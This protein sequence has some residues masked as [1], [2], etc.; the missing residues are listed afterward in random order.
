MRTLRL[1]ALSDD[2][3][4][5]G[6]RRRGQRR[7]RRR[8]A[9]RAPHRRPRCAPRPA[10]TPA[11]SPRSTSTSAPSCR[12]RVIQARIRAGE[13]PEQVAAA[14][15]TRVERIMRFAHP[16]LQERQRV[17]EQA[18]EARVRLS[19]GSP[20]VAAA[21][22][23]VRAAAAASTPT[24]TRSPGTP[25]APTTARW[26]VT[27]AWRAGDE[28]GHHPLGLRPPSRT[29]APSDAATTDFA[30]GTRLVR[31]VP[32]VP[33]G[34]PPRRHPRPPRRVHA[35]C[36]TGQPRADDDLTHDDRPP[37]TSC[38]RDLRRLR[39]AD[40]AHV[41]DVHAAGGSPDDDRSVDALL[42]EVADHDTV[43][44]GRTR[45]GEDA[46]TRAPASRPGRT[47]SSGSAATADGLSTGHRDVYRPSPGV[48]DGHVSFGVHAARR[49]PGR[50]LRQ[51]RAGAGR[52]R[53]PLRPEVRGRERDD[54]RHGP[55][56]DREGDRPADRGPRDRAPARPAAP[57]GVC[58]SACCSASSP[59][60]GG[61]WI[62]SV[63]V[64][65]ADRRGVRR[66]VRRRSA[67]PPPQGKRDFTSTSQIMAGRYDV[68]CN[69]AHAEEARA[70]L[71]RFSLRG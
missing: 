64:R 58:S 1:V 53:L 21:P 19:E 43:V 26:Q 68:M 11:G 66:A 12:P 47:S 23:H 50:V 29:V 24:S 17:A 45:G 46:R 3:Q 42:D 52:R 51:L 37:P 20:T 31:V 62:G 15:G 65:P 16:V 55:A 10:G 5:P 2:G 61:Q 59:P 7:R 8:R 69:P 30:E 63:L 13:T 33:A 71:A 39:D 49:R 25:T 44:L 56:H 40:D 27:G 4:E 35:S 67:T 18:R 32:D 36:A 54:H 34:V 60:D 6:A 22:V 48:G 14:S 70:H 57:G 9:V 38:R 41:R 28:V